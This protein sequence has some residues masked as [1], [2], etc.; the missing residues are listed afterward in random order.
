MFPSAGGAVTAPRRSILVIDDVAPTRQGLAEL[1][2]LRGYAVHE[3]EDGAEG[4]RTLR[5]N[6]QTAVVVLD[7]AMRG[8][9][10]YWFRAQQLKDP[11]LA[12]ILVVVFTGSANRERLAALRVT[13]VLIK[14]FSVDRL[15]DAVERHCAGATT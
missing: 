1:L 12:R 6:D 7:L 10:G 3:A 4:L 9:D 13:D 2:R 5:Q 14:P 15:F 8:K 11:A